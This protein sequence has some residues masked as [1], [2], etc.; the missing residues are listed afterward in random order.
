MIDLDEIEN[1]LDDASKVLFYSNIL[2]PLYSDWGNNNESIK[3]IDNALKINQNFA[4][5]HYNKGWAYI[6][7]EKMKKSLKHMMRL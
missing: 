1:K 7:L 2:G 6:N 4:D 3:F 5:A